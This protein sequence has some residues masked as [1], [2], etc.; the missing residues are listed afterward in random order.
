MSYI[1]AGGAAGKERLALLGSILNKGT[2]ALMQQLQP[3]PVSA[4]LD[5][6][7]GGGS[8]ALDVVRTGYAQEV[9]GVDFDA[10]VLQ[11]ARGDAEAEGYSNI[12]FIQGDAAAF[13]QQDRFELSYARFLLSHLSDPSLVLRNLVASTKPG[14]LVLVEDVDFPGHF[15]YPANEAFARYLEWYQLSARLSAQDPGIGPRLPRMLEEAGL[16]EVGFDLVQPAFREGAGKMMA[17][18]T[19]HKIGGT[20]LKQQLVTP[21]ELNDTLDLLKA[22]TEEEQSIISLPRIFR[23][24]G[25]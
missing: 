6:G 25:R 4:F 19:L 1:I 21:E 8:V 3:A 12:V 5:L 9:T 22:F 16:T 24:W 2:I 20:L 17:W 23:V 14:G 18:H 11:L 7:C 13:L 15:C 10:T